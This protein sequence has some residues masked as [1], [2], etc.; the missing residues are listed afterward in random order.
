VSPS[1]KNIIF[2]EHFDGKIIEGLLMS[3]YSGDASDGRSSRGFAAL[4][5]YLMLPYMVRIRMRRD[6]LIYIIN[7]I[8]RKIDETCQ[9]SATRCRNGIHHRNS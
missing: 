7:N 1:W 9:F 2:D 8:L 4:P 6:Q 3:C 5:S